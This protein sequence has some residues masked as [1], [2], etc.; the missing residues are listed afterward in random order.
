MNDQVRLE[1]PR[2][3]VTL[4]DGRTLTTQVLNPDYIR[5]DRTAAKHGWGKMDAIP[6]TWLTFVAWCAL[7]REGQIAQDVTWEDFSDRLCVQV[8]NASTREDRN[9]Q[10]DPDTVG[11]TLPGPEPG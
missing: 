4:D 9:G 3:E 8:V 2:V 6:H 7:R 5:W 10:E 11:P 1:T